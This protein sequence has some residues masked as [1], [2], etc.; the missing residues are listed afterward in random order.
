MEFGIMI[1]P[2]LEITKLED[3]LKIRKMTIGQN[4]LQQFL[5]I[6]VLQILLLRPR[7][8]RGTFKFL[9]IILI[10]LLVVMWKDITPVIHT[11]LVIA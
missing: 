1:L 4:L 6:L 9:M 10:I 5:E 2:D 8:L 7:V 3:F 11:I